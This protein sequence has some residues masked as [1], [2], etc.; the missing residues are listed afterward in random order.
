MAILGPILMLMVM[1]IISIQ[2]LYI[3]IRNDRPLKIYW[4]P[5]LIFGICIPLVVI[6][7]TLQIHTSILM[8]FLVII[9]P[10]VYL[11]S[12]LI[13]TLHF[14]VNRNTYFTQEPNHLDS[15]SFIM[16]YGAINFVI[17]VCLLALI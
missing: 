15:S 10:F 3:L 11:I 8:G 16:N 14:F 12:S 4:K 7:V 6:G 13:L 1:L 9:V 2:N 5:I 17:F